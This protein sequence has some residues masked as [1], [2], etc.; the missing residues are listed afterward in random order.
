MLFRLFLAITLSTFFGFS[1]SYSPPGPCGP[2]Q[3]LTTQLV[4]FYMPTGW[5]F[6]ETDSYH[7]VFPNIPANG[8][9]CNIIISS[10]SLAGLQISN[11]QMA[12]FIISE[13][14]EINGFRMLNKSVYSKDGAG[15][16]DISFKVDDDF[17][18]YYRAYYFLKNGELLLLN[19]TGTQ[20]QYEVLE[21]CIDDLMASARIS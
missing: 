18:G 13:Y 9:K 6:E 17:N 3:R 7:T 15:I 11:E 21:V 1:H 12:S 2:V 8:F 14:S 10:R 4:D 20:T 19:F 16:I 5:R